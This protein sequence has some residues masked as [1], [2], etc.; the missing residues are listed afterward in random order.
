MRYDRSARVDRG[1]DALLLEQIDTSC[2]AGSDDCCPER[3][4]SRCRSAGTIWN[5]THPTKHTTGERA[6]HSACTSVGHS[7]ANLE[8]TLPGW[9]ERSIAASAPPLLRLLHLKQSKQR[10]SNTAHVCRRALL[11]PL[12]AIPVHVLP[13]WSLQHR[14]SVRLKAVGP[15]RPAL[16][17]KG[18][19]R[20]FGSHIV[21]SFFT[22]THAMILSQVGNDAHVSRAARGVLVVCAY[23][24]TAMYARFCS[25]GLLTGSSVNCS[26]L[27]IDC[28]GVVTITDTSGRG[29]VA[30][31]AAVRAASELHCWLRTV[32][33]MEA[34]SFLPL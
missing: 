4:H 10:V 7:G 22:S 16:I 1:L 8:L 27:H 12:C 3:D 20:S 18:S 26:L 24:L 14:R 29:V 2:I 34:L 17:Q 25:D 21:A 32:C 23:V 9:W 33:A 11:T 5:T 31:P 19:T 30:V 13:T 15:C 6:V 28:E